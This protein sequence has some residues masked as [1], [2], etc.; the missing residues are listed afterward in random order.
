ME[1]IE[2]A[3]RER[4][5]NSIF[6]Q[7]S[8]GD[9]MKILVFYFKIVGPDWFLLKRIIIFLDSRLHK[10]VFWK[11]FFTTLICSSFVNSLNL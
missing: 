3:I 2:S 10:E 11:L 9:I 8:L 7:N 4:V 5:V 6:S 1:I